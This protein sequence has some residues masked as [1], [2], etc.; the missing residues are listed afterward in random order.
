MT[1][2]ENVTASFAPTDVECSKA[3]QELG[4]STTTNNVHIIK[5]S[6]II[7]L[8]VKPG[9]VPHVLKDIETSVTRKHLI[10][11]IAMGVKI[12]DIEKTLPVQ[13]RVVRVMPNTP[14]MV[15]CA[16]SV[17]SCGSSTTPED[18]ITTKRLLEAVGTCH[19][20]PENML[21]PITALSGSGP[22]YVYVIIEALADGGVKMGLP[23]DL[24]YSLAAQ[25]VLGSG[26]MVLET[27]LHPAILKD[28]VTSPGGST[29]AGLHHLERSA[30]RAALIGAIEAATETCREINNGT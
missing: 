16:A 6:D 10:L 22:A 1:K 7:F 28:N 4:A 20:V 9:A 15:G 25:T 3:F 11:S 17:F 23:R 19:E 12:E 24:S 26:K 13:S 21:D 30:F 18:A 5:D 2:G 29:A 27:K 8:A 14:A